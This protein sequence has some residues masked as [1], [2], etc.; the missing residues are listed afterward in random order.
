VTALYTETH[1]CPA[2]AA[3][4]TINHDGFG[5]NCV[6]ETITVNVVDA[7]AGTPLLSY[8]A[9]VQLEAR[10]FPGGALAGFGTWTRV[11][12]TGAFSD[13]A[14]NDG[15]A[16]YNWPL[17]ESQA[18]FTFSYTQGS[19]PLDIDVFQISDD[20]I[21]DN[22]AVPL[23][24][25][26]NGFTVTA[27]ALP[28]AP[29]PPIVSFAAA[30][31][32]GNTF[33]IHIAAYGQTPADPVCGII[34]AYT[35]PKSLKFWSQYANPATGAV[36]VQ[37]DGV[38][39]AGAEGSA[40]V[41]S[42]AFTAGQATVT[43]KYKDVG[44]IRVLMKDDT[45]VNPAQLPTGIRGA[46][47][48]FVVKPFSFVLSN[49]RNGPNTL[50]NPAANDANG[51]VFVAAGSPFRM[52]VTARDSE[53]T[54]T[55]NYGRETIAEGVRLDAQI[56]APAGGA[57]PAVGAAV[58]FGAFASG[59]ATGTDF[60]WQEVGVMR[61]LP[62]VGDGDYL[63]AGDVT[64]TLSERIGRFVPSHFTVALNAPL[65]ATACT[66]GGFTYLGQPFQFAT[67]PMIT[68]TAR[69]VSGALTQNYTGTFFK[70]ATGTSQN[71]TYTATTGTLNAG[72]PAPG[73]DPVVVATGPGIGT[74]TFGGGT[75]FSFAKGALQ[76]PFTAEITLALDVRDADGVLAVGA[77]PLGNPVTFGAAGGIPFSTGA[78]VRHGRIRIGTAVGSELIDLAVPMVA[79]YYHS[80]GA[81]FIANGDDTCSGGVTLAL[82][83][84]G[85]TENLDVGETCV[86]DSGAPG[87][88]GVGCAAAAPLPRYTEPPAAGDYGLRLAAP[89]AGNN[90]SVS[91]TAT[92][93]NWL[94]HDWSTGTAGD[95]DPSGQATFGIF[96]GEAKQIYIREIY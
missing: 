30:Q 53:G 77:G 11:T 57:A 33:P 47:A 1:D 40:A 96:G 48:N 12:G 34:E 66:A 63:G 8:N 35:G 50:A 62:G 29:V 95:E 64:G 70:L 2:V 58:G 28:P 56:H 37:I 92:V 17:G 55:P 73:A 71:R 85:F 24:F 39:A 72:V 54:A 9:Q 78:Q 25:S 79:E 82:P 80:A 89:G 60:T 27:A 26:P 87:A 19:T 67:A 14:A 86:R 41:Q 81:G 69:S 38:D 46:T 88:S 83:P 52:T 22:E 7:D 59:A 91:I 93:P 4:F 36:S 18:V 13:G 5:I 44:L 51:G 20:G 21:R 6:A 43:A 84:I 90:G 75:G 65:F 76:A 15:I 23:A 94:R 16:T 10:T 68:A 32:A 61:V 74:L 49:I 31:T 3:Q 42:V 45:V